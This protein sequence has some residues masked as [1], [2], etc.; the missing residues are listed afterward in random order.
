MNLRFR[1]PP[2]VPLAALAVAVLSACGAT[3]GLGAT[4]PA[5]PVS[6]QPRPEPLWS[7]WS[8]SSAPGADPTSQ[9]PPPEPLA[10][11]GALG[12]GGLAKA[13]VRELLRADT[14]LRT[15]AD[16]PLVKKPG[17]P[18]IRP[19]VLTDLTGDGKPEM[20]VAVDVESG[21]SV[22][23]VYLEKRGKVYP[24]LFTA[25][26]RLSV[27]TVGKDLLVRSPCAEGGEQAVRFHWDGTRMSTVSDV[28]SYGGKG[29][30]SPSPA[31]P[32]SPGSPG[33]RP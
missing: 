13:D 9:Q 29:G 2:G 31:D 12:P 27:E 18:G 3:S 26:R 6:V 16:R 4:E 22:L 5:P 15:L 17:R 30:S 20:L 23:V 33:A 14:R 24:V 28:K 1:I 32:G 19:P 7:A 25:G 21:R 8:G 11:L 10:G